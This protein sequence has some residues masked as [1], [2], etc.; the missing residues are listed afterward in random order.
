[1]IDYFPQRKTYTLLAQQQLALI[2]VHDKDYDRAMEI[3]E[4]MAKL[5][6]DDRA[7]FRAFGLAGK[8]GVLSL[9]GEYA[10]SNAVLTQLLPIRDKLTNEPMQ[11]LLRHAVRRNGSQLGSQ[12]ASEWEK[13]LKDQFHDDGG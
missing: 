2:Y 8:C 12:T 7:E 5:G 9:R 6:G 4:T 10:D 13:W 11:G 3:F 1:M